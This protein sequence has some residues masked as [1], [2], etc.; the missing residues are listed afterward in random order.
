M[1]RN[2]KE[3]KEKVIELVRYDN[4][5]YEKYVFSVQPLYCKSYSTYDI[6]SQYE[7]FR[8]GDERFLCVN[9]GNTVKRVY[10]ITASTPK[11]SLNQIKNYLIESVGKDKADQVISDFMY[12]GFLT[13]TYF[14]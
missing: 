4:T 3:N 1:F 5:T 2:K 10:R 8:F 14:Y 7:Y 12:Q 11:E 13:K 9:W 6:I